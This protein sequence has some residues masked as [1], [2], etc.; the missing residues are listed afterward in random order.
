MID[1]NV[2]DKILSGELNREDCDE[3]NFYKFLCLLKRRSEKQV[4]TMNDLI[5]EEFRITVKQ[6]KRKSAFSTFSKEIT[7]CMNVR[8]AVRER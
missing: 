7:R 8:C 5:E 1:D 4:D 6:S 3:A 2:I